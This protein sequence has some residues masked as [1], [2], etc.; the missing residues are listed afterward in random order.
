M[1]LARYWSAREYAIGVYEVIAVMATRSADFLAV[2]V[3]MQP[4]SIATSCSAGVSAARVARFNGGN[5]A[6]VALKFKSADT[7]GRSGRTS[8]PRTCWRH[9]GD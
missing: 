4:S 8:G 3:P 6:P 1:P 7:R 5:N 2:T 9:Y